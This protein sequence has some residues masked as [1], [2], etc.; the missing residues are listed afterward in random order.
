M[1]QSKLEKFKS[2]FLKHKV[3]FL[4]LLC[5]G[6]VGVSLYVLKD[7]YANRVDDDFSELVKTLDWINENL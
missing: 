2:H 5:L 1:E 4:V 7:S 6:F 3:M